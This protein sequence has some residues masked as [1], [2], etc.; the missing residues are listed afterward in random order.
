MR[1]IIIALVG[2]SFFGCASGPGTSTAQNTG[3]QNFF[4]FEPTEGMRW[5]TSEPVKDA[6]HKKV[7]A[8]QADKYIAVFPCK[9]GEVCQPKADDK[10]VVSMEK[11]VESVKKN[12]AHDGNVLGR[13]EEIL[14]RGVDS[15]RVQK[16][17][18]QDEYAYYDYQIQTYGHAS[19]KP[20][21]DNFRKH[22]YALGEDIKK[23]DAKIEQFEKDLNYLR[24][25]KGLNI[26]QDSST[27]RLMQMLA[28]GSWGTFG[29]YLDKQDQVLWQFFQQVGHDV[30]VN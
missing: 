13:Q 16:K 30:S 23:F 26:G 20:V 4:A 18:M 14:A 22:K 7:K 2:L 27:E 9:K 28:D 8:D 19:L 17:E 5:V 6:K 10:K 24:N 21:M 1:N 29:A 12:S 15:L 25:N 11:V 3:D